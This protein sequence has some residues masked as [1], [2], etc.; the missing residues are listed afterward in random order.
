MPMGKTLCLLFASVCLMVALSGCAAV[1]YLITG[2]WNGD[3]DV[4]V[5]S[6]T[7]AVIG[8]IAMYQEGEGRMLANARGMA[9]LERGESYGLKLDDGEENC[10]IALLD[11]DGQEVGRANIRFEGTR[12]YLTLWEDGA[13]TVSEEKP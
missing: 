9:L 6:Q 4:V 3:A 7:P 5:V 1:G 8:S 2:D 13:V 10:S 12:L 11:M